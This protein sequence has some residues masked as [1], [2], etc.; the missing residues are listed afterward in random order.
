MTNRWSIPF[1]RLCASEKLSQTSSS[2]S[3]NHRVHV[4]VGEHGHHHRV[5]VQIVVVIVVVV[6]VI[7]VVVVVGCID[8][9]DEQLS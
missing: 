5:V 1:G 8:D 6:I 4:G 3:R 7:I 2:Y 9:V